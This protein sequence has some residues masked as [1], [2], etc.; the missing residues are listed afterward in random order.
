M[1]TEKQKQI[2][3]QSLKQSHKTYYKSHR[4]EELSRLKSNNNR[5]V[6]TFECWLTEKVTSETHLLPVSDLKSEAGRLVTFVKSSNIW[7]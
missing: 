7:E 2:P 6:V 4:I 1:S 3:F 5:D